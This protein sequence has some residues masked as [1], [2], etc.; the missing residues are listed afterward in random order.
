[1]VRFGVV[2]SRGKDKTVPLVSTFMDSSGNVKNTPILR[3]CLVT[4][5]QIKDKFILDG[6]L[7]FSY[8]ELWNARY[9]KNEEISAA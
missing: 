4:N 8:L 2:V 9:A 7:P 6:E 5:Y 3:N 1:M